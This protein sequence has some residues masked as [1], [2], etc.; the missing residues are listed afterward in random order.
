MTKTLTISDD[1][2]SK[3]TDEGKKS[4]TYDGIIIRLLENQKPAIVTFSED[5]K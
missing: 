2:H 1:T 5:E 3:L 4:E